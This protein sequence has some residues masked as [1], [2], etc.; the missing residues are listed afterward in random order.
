LIIFGVVLFD[1]IHF[2]RGKA[3]FS[4][5]L[6]VLVVG[7]SAFRYKLGGDA[8]HYENIY[9]EMPR[10]SQYIQYMRYDNFY[11]Y[12]PLWI[13]LCSFCTTITPDY[14]FFQFVHSLILNIALFYFLHKHTR[15]FFSV[16]ALLW[17]SLLYLQFAIEVQRESMAIAFFLLSFPYFKQKKWIKYYLLITVSVLFHLSAIIL[18]IL[19][20]FT[21]LKLNRKTILLIIALSLAI[22]IPLRIFSLDIFVN[23]LPIEAVKNKADAYSAISFSTVGF[24]AFYFI[25]V[26]LLLPL[27]FYMRS[28]QNADAEKMQSN[29]WII[30]SLLFILSLSL[31][32]V[33]FDRFANYL[34]I[35]YFILIVNVIATYK[36][37][38]LLNKAKKNIVIFITF[39]H[40]FFIMEYK[41]FVINKYGE[42]YSS[43]FFP[44]ASIFDPQYIP[45]REDFYINQWE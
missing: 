37:E 7:M 18:F 6:F 16:F 42:R 44:Y 25:R 2:P 8:Q 22:D 33:G 11:Q 43:I 5:L 13:L 35:P 24:M 32:F 28:E 45:E 20:F 41:V 26:V 30:I 3:F 27:A 10:L 34:Y 31:G 21:I 15:Y 19:P 40:I 1:I 39:L 29:N 23:I 36:K 17:F 14:V 12:Q 38:Y 9:F 4:F